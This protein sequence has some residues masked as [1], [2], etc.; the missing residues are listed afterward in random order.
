MS[1]FFWSIDTSNVHL[2]DERSERLIQDIRDGKPSRARGITH[3]DN[4]FCEYTPNNRTE[5]REVGKVGDEV[6]IDW[7]IRISAINRIL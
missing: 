3:V 4:H 2:Y 6:D 1:Y 7:G 5:D